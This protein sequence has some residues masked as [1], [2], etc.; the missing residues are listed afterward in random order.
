MFM[1]HP[2]VVPS[3]RAL[4]ASLETSSWQQGKWPWVEQ[5]WRGVRRSDNRDSSTAHPL[6][7]WTKRRMDDIL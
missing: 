3:L 7:S 5:R 2:S 4:L 6:L 1:A